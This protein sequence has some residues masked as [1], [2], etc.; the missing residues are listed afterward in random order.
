M[1][2]LVLFLLAV[3]MIACGDDVAVNNTANANRATAT[4]TPITT[5]NANT[6]ANSN[7]AFRP[8]ET[9]SGEADFEGTAGITEK[10]NA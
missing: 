4:P 7:R 5:A 3:S 10:K 6:P 8:D 1:K 2:I 9:P